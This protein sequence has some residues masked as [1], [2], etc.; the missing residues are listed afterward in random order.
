[1]KTV[2]PNVPNYFYQ[3]DEAERAEKFAK[4]LALISGAVADRIITRAQA[5][6]MIAIAGQRPDWILSGTKLKYLG[7]V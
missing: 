6:E 3:P 7:S 4:F 1:M 2:P 5:Q